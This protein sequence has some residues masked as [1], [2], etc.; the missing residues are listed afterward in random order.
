M[1]DSPVSQKTTSLTYLPF[2]EGFK[3]AFAL[4][5]QAT[6]T[7]GAQSEKGTGDCDAGFIQSLAKFLPESDVYFSKYR[8]LTTVF[9]DSLQADSSF[10][11]LLAPGVDIHRH[12]YEIPQATK[13]VRGL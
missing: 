6:L 10:S 3:R 4:F 12:S 7:K 8:T 1:T 11:P 13:K 5:Q 2:S 9:T